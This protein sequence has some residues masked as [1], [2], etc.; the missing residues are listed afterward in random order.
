MSITWGRPSTETGTGNGNKI[1]A[2]FEAVK[3]ALGRRP[4]V[5]RWRLTRTVTRERQLYLVR[6][7]VEAER[8]ILRENVAATLFV[9]N[10]DEVGS[11]SFEIKPGQEARVEGEIA[12]A[13]RLAKANGY[14]DYPKIDAQPLP[15]VETV[16]PEIARNPQR[17]LE[18][19]REEVTGATSRPN[20][21]LASAEFFVIHNE[22]W[23]ENSQG[24][25]ADFCGTRTTGEVVILGRDSQGREAE[26][27]DLRYRRRIEDLDVSG[28]ATE[29]GTHA[30]D[31][32]RAEVMSSWSG[33]VVLRSN[34]LDSFVRPIVGQLSGESKYR[35]MSSFEVG[36]PIT[37]ETIRGDRITI[38]SDRT[39][40]FG[41]STSPC[42]GD[43]VP[44]ARVAVVEDGR[45]RRFWSDARHAHYL[46]L[47]ATGDWANLVIEPGSRSAASLTSGGDVLEVVKF[48]WFTPSQGTG[49]F[50]S[51]MR[52]GY[53]H[54]G[55]RRIP[56][57]G[58]AV[59]G[60]VY[61]G[62]SHAYFSRETDFIGDGLVPSRMRLE[63]MEIAGV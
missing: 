31:G 22:S 37:E 49:D 39:L 45:V 6:H 23:M 21:N 44:A 33:P 20:V 63:G 9:R 46:G 62:L 15:T 12:T 36:D 16:D 17:G 34:E 59:T 8:T 61:T 60:N 19:L 42:D 29:L 43:G 58:G 56:V 35:Q 2:T 53:L 55:G 27:Q 18:R 32:A 40:P 13:V 3:T 1:E 4:D 7:D 41:L 28:W 10:G 30:Q 25:E 38:A 51:E 50:A 14:R 54:R 5:D 24:L 57:K 48:S 52:F 47:K 11:S 26:V